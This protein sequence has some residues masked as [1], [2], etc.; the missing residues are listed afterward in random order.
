M[1]HPQALVTLATTQNVASPQ[2]NCTPPLAP[3][4]N[5]LAPD[6]SFPDPSL[7]GRGYSHGMPRIAASLTPAS[8][9]GGIRMGLRERPPRQLQ[10][11]NR[12]V[13]RGRKE[14]FHRESFEKRREGSEWGGGGSCPARASPQVS[15][16]LPPT[17]RTVCLS[18]RP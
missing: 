1:S 10:P 9:A 14:H 13:R 16:Q 17:Q 8:R 15:P 18:L 4:P 11:V 6:R 3:E 5:N 2:A 12:W 7:A